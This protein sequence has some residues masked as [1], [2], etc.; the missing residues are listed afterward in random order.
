MRISYQYV[1]VSDI[2]V[3]DSFV[4]GQS[5]DLEATL[6]LPSDCFI[7][8]GFE[9]D[10]FDNQRYVRAVLTQIEANGTC[11]NTEP[12]MITEQLTFQALQ[13]ED[14]IFKFLTGY[15]DLGNEIYLEYTIPVTL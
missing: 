1:G 5:Y 6:E 8:S 10:I 2:V 3:P 13:R 9:M 12:Q 11:E 7:F 4:L 14:Y 15:D